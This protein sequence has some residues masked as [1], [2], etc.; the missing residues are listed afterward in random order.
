MSAPA[1]LLLLC[2]RQ[3]G[4]MS[5]VFLG[6]KSRDGFLEPTPTEMQLGD[7]LLKIFRKMDIGRKEFVE[8]HLGSQGSQK[9]LVERIQPTERRRNNGWFKITTG[10]GTRLFSFDL[11]VSDEADE[12]TLRRRIAVALGRWLDIAV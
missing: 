3:N 11:H 6:G 7:A 1:A 4:Q 8:V 2:A 10:H 9:L 12:A 5:I